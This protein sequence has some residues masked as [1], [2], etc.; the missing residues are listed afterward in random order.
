MTLNSTFFFQTAPANMTI[1]SITATISIAYT[2][3]V[4]FSTLRYTTKAAM[5]NRMATALK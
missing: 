5:D 3:V 4:V 2:G 1:S